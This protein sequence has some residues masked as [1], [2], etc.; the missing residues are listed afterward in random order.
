MEPQIS[1]ICVDERSAANF[2]KLM[3]KI[4]THMFALREYKKMV[5][6]K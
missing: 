5:A 4:E 1:K 6:E 3:F 2:K